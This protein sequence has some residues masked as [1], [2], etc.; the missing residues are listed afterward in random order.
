MVYEMTESKFLTDSRN[1]N[2]TIIS[3]VFLDL[4]LLIM[5]VL[6]AVL[7]TFQTY[8]VDYIG[9]TA[10]KVRSFNPKLMNLISLFI[11]LIGFCFISIAIT[12][13]IIIFVSIRKREK[14]YWLMYIIQHILVAFPLIWLTFIVG[15]L[16][17]I[18]VIIGWIL[19]IIGIVFSYKEIFK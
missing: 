19:I 16:A 9:M 6:Y 11:R 15:G 17:F 5:G 13:M 18:L 12:G 7:G 14:S 3:F 4:L 1:L 2:I 10:S 8:H